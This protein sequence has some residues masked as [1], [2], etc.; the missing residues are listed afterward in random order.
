MARRCPV[1]WAMAY[2]TPVGILL[3]LPR[4]RLRRADRVCERSLLRPPLF[5]LRGG[6]AH[7]RTQRDGLRLRRLRLASARAN[8]KLEFVRTRGLSLDG[9]GELL[10]DLSK[11]CQ[12]RR[13]PLPRGHPLGRR[14]IH[15]SRARLSVGASMGSRCHVTHWQ[16]AYGGQK[17]RSLF[18]GKSLKR[19][20]T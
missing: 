5:D 11:R 18:G 2:L 7:R 13:L 8:L 6:R 16:Q 12:R 3:N 10:L 15:D 17:Q 14:L 9:L 19:P 1:R 4:R 20:V